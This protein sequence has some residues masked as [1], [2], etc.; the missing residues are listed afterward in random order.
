MLLDDSQSTFGYAG[1]AGLDYTLTQALVFGVEVRYQGSLKKSY[2][3]TAQ[4]AAATGLSS[5]DTSLD[6]LTATLKIGI[7]Y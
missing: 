2:A 4:G 7:K 3:L 6:V 5:I 1:G